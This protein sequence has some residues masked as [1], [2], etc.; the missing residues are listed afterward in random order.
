MKSKMPIENYLLNI[1]RNLI[2]EIKKL[3]RNSLKLIKP[4]MLLAMNTKDKTMMIWSLD[5]WF[6]LELITYL[7]TSSVTD[8]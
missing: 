5:R 2:L 3:T 4:T 8:G 7:M 6:P 1:T